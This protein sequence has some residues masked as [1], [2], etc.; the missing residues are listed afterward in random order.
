MI[1]YYDTLNLKPDCTPEDIKKAY[2]KLSIKFHPDKNDGDEY[3]TDM[4][5]KINDANEILSNTAKRADY[6]WKLKNFNL[7]SNP[8]PE[9]KAEPN[10]NT[11]TPHSNNRARERLIKLTEDYLA[12]KEIEEKKLQEF[13]RANNIK[14]P[15]YL[16]A[17]HVLGGVLAMLIVLVIYVKTPNDNTIQA[18]PAV[19]E[20][21]TEYDDSGEHLEKKREKQVLNT[22]ETV[23][24]DTE[25]EETSIKPQV[26]L[27]MTAEEIMAYDSAPKYEDPKPSVD[28]IVNNTSEEP[29][30]KKGFFKRVFG[31]KESNYKPPTN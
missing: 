28:T 17:T 6:D 16:T 26:K 13:Q 21:P 7:N 8:Q 23:D 10:R 31:K 2:R 18:K 1:N 9:P 5:R 24:E 12:K 20:E 25:T 14:V 29:Q 30:K 11:T 15:Q 22:S 27:Q 4:F 3:F 19:V